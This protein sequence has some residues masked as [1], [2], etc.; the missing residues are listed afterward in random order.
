MAKSKQVKTEIIL[1]KMD[2]A[3][4]KGDMQ[5]TIN[6]GKKILASTQMTHDALQRVAMMMMDFDE[7][8]IAQETLTK[9]VEKYTLNGYDGL[10]FTRL[11]YLKNDYEHAI[12]WG[13]EA[14]LLGGMTAAQLAMTHNLLGHIYRVLGELDT[15]L[16]HFARSKEE[17]YLCGDDDKYVATMRAQDYSN[18]LFT[19][20][21][22]NVSPE[23]IYEE[24]KGYGA[25][26]RGIKPFEHDLQKHQHRR[27][28]IGY[29]SP[30]LRRH[31]VAFF[32]YAFLK[33][34]DRNNFAVYAY[35]NNKEDGVS[36]EYAACVDG[37]R[38][39]LNVS[40]Y[41]VAKQI[42]ADEI[43]ILVDLAGHTANNSLE[44]LAYKP[45]PVQISGVGY[46]D[47]T[48]LNTVDY[49]IADT[50]TAP[51]EEC[52]QFF[53]EKLLRL[54][55]SH[56]CYMWHDAPKPIEMSPYRRNGYVTFGSFNNFTKVNDE[57]MKA[58]GKIMALVP[59]SR[60]M[61]KAKV[62][63]I[64]YCRKLVLSRMEKAGIPLERVII[65]E[66]EPDYL[67]HY[68]N[69]DIA[70]DTFPY[71]GG[72]TTCD[73]LY[74]GVPVI[75]LKGDKHHSRFGYSI[76][77]NLGLPEL[78]AD[79]LDEYVERA[80]I[81]AQNT[82]ML[83][84]LHQTLRRRI[85]QSPVMDVAQYMMEIET[86]YKKVWEN[87]LAGNK[88]VT[89]TV[90]I[91]TD[92]DIAFQ[93]GRDFFL[94]MGG[95]NGMLRAKPWL[96]RAVELD[97]D[98]YKPAMLYSELC[99][100]LK[101]HVGAYES[102]K[103]CIERAKHH[104]VEQPDTF[105]PSIYCRKAYAA[106]Q[107]GYIE[108][109]FE[110]YNEA[111]QSA[112]RYS[113]DAVS[114]FDSMLLCGH[115]LPFS[116]QDMY[117]LHILY[118][119]QIEKIAPLIQKESYR[120][121][122]I[123]IGYISPD[124]RRHVMFPFYYGMVFCY[125]KANFTVYCY[126]NNELEDE[127][128][129][130]IRESV[131]VFVNVSNWDNDKI[132]QCIR[133][134]EIDVL[135]DLAGHTSKSALPVL[136]YR[137]APIQMSGIGYLS[138]TGLGEVDYFITDS[139][140][141]PSGSHETYFT[142]KLFYMQSH[143]SY[144]VQNDVPNPQGTAAK[145]NGYI[146]FGV[147]NHYRKVTF[148][149]L[150]TWRRIMSELPT[151][152]ILFKSTEFDSDSLTDAAFLRL[153]SM[154]F[155]MERVQFEAADEGYMTRYLDVDIAL[156]T[157]PYTGGRT[158]LDAL[159]MG[160]PVI[161]LYGE[162]RNTRFGLSI[163]A[164][165]GLEELAVST[166]DE[167]V[168]K[169]VALGS[170]LSLLDTLH[171]QLRSML[172]ACKA[173]NPIVYVQSFEKKIQDLVKGDDLKEMRGADPFITVCYIAC[174]EEENLAVSLKSI[175]QVA[176]EIVVVDTGSNDNTVSVAQKYGANVYSF[177]WCDDFAKAR[178][179]ALE[180]C[181]GR[182][183]LFLDAD[184]YFPSELAKELP[185]IIQ[186]AETQNKI[187]LLV[188]LKN[189]DVDSNG[190]IIDEIY[191][192]RLF[193]NKKE[194]RYVGAIHEELQYNEND[195][196]DV[197]FVHRDTLYIIH[198]GYS[199]HL[200]QKKAKRNLPLLL[201]ELNESSNP[202]RVYS[203]LADAYFGLGDM[204]NAK[205]YARMDVER[206]RRKVTGASRSFRILLQILAKG[207][208]L[209]ER[210][211]TARL[212]VDAFPELPE[213]QAELAECLFVAGKR[214]EAVTAGK[215]ALNLWQSGIDGWE[216]TSF[217]EEMADILRKRIKKWNI[218]DVS[219][220]DTPLVSIMI[221][222]YNR[223]HMF[224]EALQSCLSQ[225][226]AHLEILV[227]DNS[228]NDDTECIMQKYMGDERVYYQRNRETKSKADNFAPFEH[229]ARGEYLQWLMD[230]DMLAPNKISKMINVF[231]NHSNVK[232]VTSR[233]GIVDK[234]AI[235]IKQYDVPLTIS[236]EYQIYTGGDL[237]IPMLS[238]GNNFIGEPSAVLF[239][240]K[241]LNH[242]YWRAESNGY[243][244]LSDVSMWL[245][246]LEHGDGVIFAEPLSF[247]RNHA[248]Q[249]GR[250]ADVILLS[251]LEWIRLNK[252]YVNKN[253]FKYSYDKYWSYMNFLIDESKN[254]RTRLADEP[255]KKMWEKYNREM[256]LL[257]AELKIM[258]E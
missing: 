232:L 170:D 114:M 67:S 86:G 157:Y 99:H 188:N 230:D 43:D 32:S 234:N 104:N 47:T 254:I 71:P 125:N 87:W 173:I 191:V 13:E 180:R 116:S 136:A 42:Y 200:T 81:L 103:I 199:S 8:E 251:R 258:K 179:Y 162:R 240:R 150:E 152:R 202:E 207:T 219:I 226:Y 187:A 151:S 175:A 46:F 248:E 246:L 149:M 256:A 158:T 182:W 6:L 82:E 253:V 218:L 154:G 148:E 57:V 70:L 124:F 5:E 169:A 190:R 131:D 160:V 65:E 217:T 12:K 53:V 74:M 68:R 73:A 155:D 83:S 129:Q 228:T 242:H 105:W 135:V 84:D 221:P 31:V 146:T 98:A 167:Y 238:Q 112:P 249:E 115:L 61:L 134:D 185:A 64:E 132:A 236:G 44:V 9:L 90:E 250:Q 102:A 118:Q 189:I 138:T 121:E 225:D 111:W 93:I 113:V 54:P 145:E 18:Y 241:D 26:W 60:L 56:L 141:D 122:K 227:C 33:N 77:M 211:D 224:E 123:R 213:F 4:G 23:Y 110:A 63:N 96:K 72:G 38:N 143:F 3:Y 215:K 165:I 29:I 58:W 119:K 147:F 163:L 25:L 59:D 109:A 140:V 66:H 120:H 107:L 41:D 55:H 100:Q 208:D 231:S 127:Y 69:M 79:N 178:N 130:M 164:N 139:F 10:L 91:C 161:S 108:E 192:M 75:T 197:G 172:L 36:Q 198:T 51:T 1:N 156:D 233:R 181:H 153:K 255:S 7:L 39:I 80:V 205:K 186:K 137:P 177:N 52:E 101:D 194:L 49:V 176:D 183:I 223:P 92:A 214:K 168:V 243:L 171:G 210:L 14:L 89:T 85:R 203:F 24:S 21:Y 40:A 20:H 88:P 35:A 97:N 15:A 78:C 245:E 174:N 229:L 62:F 216:M 195:I 239:R 28:R 184:E 106:M 76:M 159:Y 45:A 2:V 95:E 201:R 252:Y 37:W 206:G 128:T 133:S 19:L 247:Y 237:A 22:M 166:L 142:E 50:Y 222:T 126:H 244:T 34:Y 30:D 212:A 11:A 17:N 257:E 48:G 144:A 196:K 94:E 117:D 220:H 204:K 209:Q 27:V 193:C 16:S 235:F